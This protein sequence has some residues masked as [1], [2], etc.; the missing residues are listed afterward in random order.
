MILTAT[1]CSVCGYIFPEGEP[2]TPCPNC[3]GTARTF[4]EHLESQVEVHTGLR[5]RHRRPGFPGYLADMISRAKRSLKG[6]V[7]HEELTIDRSDPCKTI[8]THR[9]SERQPDGSWKTVHDE[10]EEFKAKRRPK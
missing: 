2:R 7:A 9:V 8:K 3:G 5:A 6:I 1:T 10:R 4:H